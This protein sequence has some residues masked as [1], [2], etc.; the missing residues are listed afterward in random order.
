M[1]VICGETYEGSRK[2]AS[3]SGSGDRVA[4]VEVFFVVLVFFVV[5]AVVVV[6]V[7]GLAVVVVDAVVVAEEVVDG[8]VVVNDV[9]VVEL[10]VLGIS[11]ITG[12]DAQPTMAVIRIKMA[13][14]TI[15]TR[16][17]A[18]PPFQLLLCDE[19]Q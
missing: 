4:L 18:F 7:V 2:S 14:T 5:V 9:A 11:S 8:A 3:I 17:I 19:R 12:V 15:I 1:S 13:V 10:V 6:V 16:L